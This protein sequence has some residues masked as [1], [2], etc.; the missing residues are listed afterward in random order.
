MLLEAPSDG[1]VTLDVVSRDSALMTVFEVP[2]SIGA[3]GY[4]IT[5]STA[6]SDA[7]ACARCL[8]QEENALRWFVEEK[9]PANCTCPSDDNVDPCFQR[10]SCGCYCMVLGQLRGPCPAP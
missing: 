6:P 3:D 5:S 4:A 10:E 2:E 9:R 7:P 8:L 1:G